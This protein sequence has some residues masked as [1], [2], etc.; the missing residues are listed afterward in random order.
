MIIYMI[1]QRSI[2]NVFSL[3]FSFSTN[4][5]FAFFLFS[6]VVLYFLRKMTKK[7]RKFPTLRYE[8]FICVCVIASFVLLHNDAKE[9]FAFVL[10]RS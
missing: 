6:C 8:I 9:L 7:K 3:S 2:Q 1:I 5:Y 10:L 4:F